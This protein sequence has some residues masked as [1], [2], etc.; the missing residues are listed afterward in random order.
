MKRVSGVLLYFA[1][2]IKILA[3]LLY[4]IFRQSFETKAIVNHWAE[5]VLQMLL[6]SEKR[7]P[8]NGTCEVKN[9]YLSGAIE[10]P[11]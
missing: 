1:I 9:K 8:S 10:Q 7:L 3:L 4:S 2:C 11:A 5:H 6:R